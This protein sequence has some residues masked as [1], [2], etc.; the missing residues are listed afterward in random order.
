MNEKNCC[1]PTLPTWVGLLFLLLIAG[2]VFGLGMLAVSITERRAEA[3]KRTALHEIAVKEMDAEKWGLNYPR[4]FDSWKATK[5]TS[6]TSKFG[7]SGHRDYLEETPANVI[8]FAGYGFGKDYCQARGHWYAV[9]DVTETKRVNE[10]TPASCWYCKSPDV[11]RL[12]EEMGIEKFASHTFDELKSEITHAISCYD[13][14]EENTMKLRVLRPGIVK[15]FEA[16]GKKMGDFTH[17]QMR[18]IVC[19]QC[20]S[21]YYFEPDTNIV[22]F[23]WSKGTVVENIEEYYKEDGFSDWTHPI[24]KVRIIKTRH[25]DYEIFSTSVHAFQGVSCADCHTPY[26]TEGAEKFSDHHLRSPLADISNTCAVCHRWS[27]IEV[28]SRVTSIQEK[29]REGRDRAESAL[30]YAH[31]DI[32]ACMEAGAN[33]EELAE[34]RDLMRYAQMDWDFIASSN[35]MG[36]HSPQES[37]RILAASLDKA[38]QVRIACGKILAK[39][40]YAEDVIYPDFST[41]EKAQ[42]L[43][44]QYVAG[45]APSLLKKGE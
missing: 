17:Q 18:S 38:S 15:G 13:C 27:E 24:S 3:V 28:K 8:L 44:A 31:F 39:H 20:H 23:P 16:Q 12:I 1:N 5:D 9:Q 35:G 45:T 4:Q 43:T 14:H 29:I 40:S 32:A 25:P 34:A 22:T 41:K 36:F 11:P 37:Q 21:T 30:A 42:A 33:D 6:F 19:A 26:K 10:K 2:I 7:G